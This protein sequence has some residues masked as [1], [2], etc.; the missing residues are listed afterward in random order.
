MKSKVGGK[1]AA[2]KGSIITITAHGDS[3]EKEPSNVEKTLP[4]TEDPI[5]L[6]PVGDFFLDDGLFPPQA[7]S[8]P[9]HDTSYSTDM[10]QSGMYYAH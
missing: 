8:S 3:S 6:E 4:P 2:A 10:S 1:K 9:Q 7:N 5:D